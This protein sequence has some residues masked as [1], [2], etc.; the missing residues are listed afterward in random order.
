MKETVKVGIGGYAFTCDIDAYE[1]LDKYLNNLKSYFHNKA[2]A[3]EI[4][5]DI[6]GRMSELLSLKGEPPGYIITREDAQDIINIMGDPSDIVDEGDATPKPEARE[7]K[8]ESY[9][10]A[11]RLYR[12][13]DNA[14]FGGVFSGL[15][16]Y[17]RIDPV[18]LR[19]IYLVIMFAWWGIFDQ[20]GGL[21]ILA[22]I[23]LWI[24]VPKANTFDQK[25][26]MTGKD[27]SVQ[28]IVS[29]SSAKSTMRGSGVGSA[30]KAVLKVIAG[31]VLFM[32][33]LFSLLMAFS[34]FVAPSF[35]D[36]P[37]AKYV[38]ETI[39][40]YSVSAV[41]ALSAVWFIP[42][43]MFIYLIIR[44]IKGFTLRDLAVLGIAF[45]AFIGAGLYLGVKGI[46]YAKNYKHESSYTEKF[47][48]SL[49]S[50]TLTIELDSK[51]HY[52]EEL[53]DSR[54]VY[55]ID[56]NGLKSWFLVPGIRI[57]RD[58]AFTQMEIEIKKQ[59]FGKNQQIALD[60]AKNARF[61][62]NQSNSTVTL[63]PHLYNEN[64]PWD[65]EGFSITIYCPIDKT[66]IVDK[67]LETKTRG[68]KR[69]EDMKKKKEAKK[70]IPAVR[71]SVR[72]DSTNDTLKVAVEK[73]IL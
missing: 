68:A 60:K 61:D 67:I 52:S 27:P 59:A 45:L 18:I 12:D 65:R 8:K 30:L 25:L 15:G 48:P 40:L 69:P 51:Y 55:F 47:V 50:D 33:A 53:F 49:T 5:N 20:Y 54:D 35:F 28:N 46:N 64:N 42:A 62:I 63:N 72:N 19:I 22:Y 70:E 24:V 73:Q 7:K 32:I 11:K 23:I 26:A 36:L 16:Y 57:K 41:I 29:G 1:I 10:S 34:A 38:L 14:I 44:L 6:E 3:V 56:N 4:I 66:I 2:D 43:F 9:S 31:I 71:D 17:F 37:S 58:S 21:M 39:G 13:P